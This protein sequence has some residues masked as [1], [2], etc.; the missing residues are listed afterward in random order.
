MTGIRSDISGSGELQITHKESDSRGFL[1][2]ELI[3]DE[4]R[5]NSV[6]KRQIY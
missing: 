6:K 3:D 4:W 1:I 2:R 5:N